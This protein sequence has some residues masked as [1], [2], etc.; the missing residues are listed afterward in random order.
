[1]QFSDLIE[2]VPQWG[3]RKSRTKA[4]PWCPSQMSHLIQ[5]GTLC[6]LGLC[7]PQL[8]NCSSSPCRNWSKDPTTCV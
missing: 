2:D 3:G 6:P 4:E 8:E 1:M 5:K 7:R